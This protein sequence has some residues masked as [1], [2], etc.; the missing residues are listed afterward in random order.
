MHLV[1]RVIKDVLTE[2]DGV[3]FDTARILWAVGTLIFFGLTIFT[4]IKNPTVPFN[5]MNWGI[6]FGGI[7]AGGGA[8]VKIKESTEQPLPGGGDSITNVQEKS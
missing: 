2:K 7:L 6:A 5:Y 1:S 8:S 4:V 3:S